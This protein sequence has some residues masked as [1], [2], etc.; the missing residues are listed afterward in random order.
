ML[1]TPVACII[2]AA[3]SAILNKAISNLT[4]RRVVRADHTKKTVSPSKLPSPTKAKNIVKSK[5]T[6]AMV[7][8]RNGVFYVPRC[9]EFNG[10]FR[11]VLYG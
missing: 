4:D 7:S 11:V 2:G 9:D 3:I 5:G 1:M 6:K 8:K 10:V